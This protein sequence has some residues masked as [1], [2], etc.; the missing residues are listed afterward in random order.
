M[1]GKRK[2]KRVLFILI[3][4]CF[5]KHT[6]HILSENPSSLPI[7]LRLRFQIAVLHF[8]IVNF[9]ELLRVLFLW[10]PYSFSRYLK[11]FQNGHPDTSACE[12]ITPRNL[13]IHGILII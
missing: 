5:N 7:I 3:V 8:Y 6:Y 13:C 12:D 11:V 9:K 1:L 2:Y 10:I 4:K